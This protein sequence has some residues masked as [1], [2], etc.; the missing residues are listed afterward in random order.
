LP[1]SKFQSIS[2]SVTGS[3]TID[4]GDSVIQDLKVDVTGS[5]GAKSF[6][7]VQTGTFTVTGSGDISGNA[8]RG[9]DVDKNKIGSGDIRIRKP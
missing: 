5:G 6:T 9:C 4:L 8:A 1:T 7:A 2:A 3:G